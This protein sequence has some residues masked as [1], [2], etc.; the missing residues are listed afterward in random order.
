MVGGGVGRTLIQ[1]HKLV[2]ASA[3]RVFF[4]M[5]YGGLESESTIEIPD[6]EPDSFRI[7]LEVRQT[8]L[9]SQYAYS[10]DLT[11]IFLTFPSSTFTRE[12]FLLCPSS[13]N[14]LT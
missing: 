2:L 14:C 4:S 3:S 5:F 13:R 11:R 10:G 6:C 1:A 12:S 8:L 9:K 7:A